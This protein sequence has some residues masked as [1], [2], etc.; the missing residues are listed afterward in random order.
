LEQWGESDKAD[1]EK[2]DAALNV[3]STASL[4]SKHLNKGPGRN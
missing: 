3:P 2:L 1:W 4:T